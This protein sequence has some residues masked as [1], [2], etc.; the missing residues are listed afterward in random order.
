LVEEGES[1]KNQKLE[2]KEQ[3]DTSD[4]C[5]DFWPLICYYMKWR[6]RIQAHYFLNCFFKLRESTLLSD[7][8]FLNLNH[9]HQD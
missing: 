8:F 7:H 9:G 2:E 3:N 1:K 5:F 4:L 6:V